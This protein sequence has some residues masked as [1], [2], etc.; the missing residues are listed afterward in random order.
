MGRTENPFIILWTMFSVLLIF[1]FNA[2]KLVK[3]VQCLVDKDVYPIFPWS[4]TPILSASSNIWLINH[5]LL[6][7]FLVFQIGW[8]II[9][10]WYADYEYV[11]GNHINWYYEL[12]HYFNC[13][14]ILVNAINF[15]DLS[16]T[17][18]LIINIG[19]ITLLIVLFDYSPPLYL[20]VLC[21][22]GYMELVQWC[23]EKKANRIF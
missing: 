11:W 4:K 6:S 10:G 18:A 13:A 2:P 8:K 7:L 5:L 22:P 16:V 23:K 14:F 17:K 9:F 3:L 21:T 20:T 19:A 15:A 1:G 12:F